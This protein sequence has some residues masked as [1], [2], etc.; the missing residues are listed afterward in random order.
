MC[1]NGKKYYKYCDTVYQA[2]SNKKIS[3]FYVKVNKSIL[4]LW[5]SI[6]YQAKTIENDDRLLQIQVTIDVTG[7]ISMALH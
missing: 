4:F 7:L 1:T 6:S 5:F 3:I 2:E